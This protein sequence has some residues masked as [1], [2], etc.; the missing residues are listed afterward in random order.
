MFEFEIS[1]RFVRST[2]HREWAKELLLL[3][4]DEPFLVISYLVL[5]DSE[6]YE[7]VKKRLCN[8][9][10]PE[11]NG[12]EWQQRLR[13]RSKERG[14]R[15]NGVK[16]PLLSSTAFLYILFLSCELDSRMALGAR[17]Q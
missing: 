13:S 15:T 4:E 5:A 1:I 9:F 6:Y 11:G 17:W 8:R 3:L 2:R 12:I 7:S 14:E 16:V 10:P